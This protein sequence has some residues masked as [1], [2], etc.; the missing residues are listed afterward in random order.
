MGDQVI[1]NFI[2]L[3]A[4]WSG[5]FCTLGVAILSRDIR[6]SELGIARI[7]WLLAVFGIIHGFHEWLE[8][9][10]QLDR[11]SEAPDFAFF[12][13]AMSACLSCSCFYFG[14]FLN[15][16]TIYGDQALKDDPRRGKDAYRPVSPLSL[17]AGG[18]RSRLRQPEGYLYPHRRF[19]RR[20]AVGNRPGNLLKNRTTFSSGCRA[21]FH[22]RRQVS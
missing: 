11:L 7:I 8:L 21:Q 5:F 1:W 9:L 10:E 3:S 15:I 17:S 16:I 14:L 13:P 22:P 20:V 4:L 12:R 6:L 2:L 18:G 19:P